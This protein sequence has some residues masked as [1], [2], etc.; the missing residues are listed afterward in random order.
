[1][2]ELLKAFETLKE[3]CK[4]QVTSTGKPTCMGCVFN[5]TKDKYFGCSVY[6]LAHD[7][8]SETKLK[9]LSRRKI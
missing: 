4:S 9:D 2:K 3:Y 1:M 5:S 6:Y 8:R 7:E